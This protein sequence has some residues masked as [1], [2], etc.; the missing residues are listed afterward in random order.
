LRSCH[1]DP[2]ISDRHSVPLPS[3]PL[4]RRA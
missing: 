3:P 2:A 4:H 1:A